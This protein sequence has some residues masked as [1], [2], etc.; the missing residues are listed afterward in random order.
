MSSSEQVNSVVVLKVRTWEG[1]GFSFISLRA[2]AGRRVK[3]DGKDYANVGA[4]V[5]GLTAS[6]R[7]VN[8]RTVEI[9]DKISGEG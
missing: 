6:A 1:D 9:T 3:F 4:V 7:R 8:E 5:D 2:E